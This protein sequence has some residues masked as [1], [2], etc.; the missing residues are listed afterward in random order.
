MYIHRQGRLVVLMVLLMA[1]VGVGPRD[2]R[3]QGRGHRFGSDGS[4]GRQTGAGQSMEP[5]MQ[6][7]SGLMQKMAERLKAGPLTPDQ[8]L[9][10]S[11]MMEQ[12]ATMMSKMA[13]G[14]PG[15]DTGSL[16]A[17]MKVR[18]AEMQVPGSLPAKPS[19]STGMD[20]SSQKP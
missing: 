5:Q 7:M 2:L 18:L 12:L 16:L 1:M 15:A 14:I 11:G 4:T 6:Q 8:A 10:L 13:A 20:A 9:H 19:A 17:D 3:A